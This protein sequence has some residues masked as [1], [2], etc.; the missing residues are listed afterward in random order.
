MIVFLLF[1]NVNELVFCEGC[2][3]L[4]SVSED[5]VLKFFGLGEVDYDYQ[6]YFLRDMEMVLLRYK[7]GIYFYCF[8]R[9][10]FK[11]LEKLKFRIIL[12]DKVI[13]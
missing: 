12:N 11:I 9:E 2:N 13:I 7:K 4:C 3:Y 6:V 5:D 10:G 1:L 8:N